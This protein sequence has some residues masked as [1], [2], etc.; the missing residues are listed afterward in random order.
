MSSK[1]SKKNSYSKP[2][3]KDYKKTY[4]VNKGKLMDKKI[5]TLLERKMVSIANAEIHKN[6][7]VLIKRKYHYLVYDPITNQY[8]DGKEIDFPGDVQ[9][10]HD[11]P[12]MDINMVIAAPGPDDP[13]TEEK[14]HVPPWGA[15]HGMPTTPLQGT[16][17]TDQVKLLSVTLG[18][19]VL[20]KQTSQ[21][22]RVLGVCRIKY[23]IVGIQ[24]EDIGTLSSPLVLPSTKD[25]LPWKRYGY[26]RRLDIQDD[27]NQLK[28]K[29]R[30]FLK[31]SLDLKYNQNYNTEKFV[32]K[33]VK[34][35][36]P[37]LLTYDPVD[38]TGLTPTRWRIYLIFRSSVPR[39]QGYNFDNYY[40]VIHA[41]TKLNY[42]EP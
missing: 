39:V 8:R 23:A 27:V 40:P 20:L 37:L 12:K 38:Q 7:I 26:D 41:W 33:F 4:N 36:N 24:D 2:K 34:L 31:G 42:Y 35:N 17:Q 11:I 16:R 13:D 3:K 19:R 18:F 30:I 29:T 5:N 6:R 28:V 25:L 21:I 10:L 9:L 22:D 15:V 14:E 32:T 1:Y